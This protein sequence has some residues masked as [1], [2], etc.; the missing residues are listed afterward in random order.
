[1]KWVQL[2]IKSKVLFHHFCLSRYAQ[3]SVPYKYRLNSKLM[4]RMNFGTL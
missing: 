2:I 4:N 1:M 3:Q